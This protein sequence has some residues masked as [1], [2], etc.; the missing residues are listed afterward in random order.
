MAY[1]TFMYSSLRPLKWW[2]VEATVLS[3]LLLSSEM[4]MYPSGIIL[5]RRKHKNAE[6]LAAA[7][8]LGLSQLDRDRSISSANH[9]P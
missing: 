4:N 8:G 2:A 6:D 5:L 3:L 9:H 7:G 1:V